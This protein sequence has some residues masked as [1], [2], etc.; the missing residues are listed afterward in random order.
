[1]RKIT[2]FSRVFS[3]GEAGLAEVVVVLVVV[4]VM[5]VGATAML[6]VER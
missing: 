1:M 6:M 4:V 5:F 3:G 2:P